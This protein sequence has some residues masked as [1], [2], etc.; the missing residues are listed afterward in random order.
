[1][2]RSACARMAVPVPVPGRPRN[3]S[4]VVRHAD[5]IAPQ[6]GQNSGRA[7]DIRGGV[8]G[9]KEQQG[10]VDAVVVAEERDVNF[11]S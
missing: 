4:L 3:K 1:M 5:P 11:Y 10:G 9:E 2:L 7:G 6:S 8:E